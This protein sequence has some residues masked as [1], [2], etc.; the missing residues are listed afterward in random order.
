MRKFSFTLLVTAVFATPA[1][2]APKVVVSILPLH[3]LVASVMQGA[4][5]PELLMQGQNSEHNASFTPAQLIGLEKADLVFLIGDTLETKLANLSGSDAVNNKT[6]V[7][8]AETAGLITHATR[9]GGSWEPDVDEKAPT[10]NDTDPHL[11]LDP[12]NASIMVQQIAKALE[13]TDPANAAIYAANAKTTLTGLN[14]LEAQLKIQL[15]PLH[16]KPFIVFHDAYQYFERHFGLA[17]VGSISNFAASPPS[18]QRL[19]EI[20]EKI[21]SSHAACVFREPQYNDAAVATVV[22]G[23]EAKTNVLDAIGA[24]LEPGPRAYGQLLHQ[25]ADRMTDC[26]Q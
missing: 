22:E 23:T 24:T 12:E 2:A 17:G 21:L 7:K 8:L 19:G 5:E 15:A 10:P 13:Q 16:N 25:I 18:A 14:V 4:G 20:H 9:Q 3:S 11:W 1:F 6:F 26:L